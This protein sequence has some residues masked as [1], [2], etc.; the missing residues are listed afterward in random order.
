VLSDGASPRRRIE[1]RARD[2][3]P[4]PRRDD[5]DDDEENDDE[6]SINRKSNRDV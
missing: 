3:A 6:R 5:D 2:D 4:R 1:S